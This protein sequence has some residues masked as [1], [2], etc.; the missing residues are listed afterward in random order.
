MLTFSER[1]EPKRV[2]PGAYLEDASS[3]G[4]SSIPSPS[5]QLTLE[6]KLSTSHNRSPTRMPTVKT[7]LLMPP[8]ETRMSSLQHRLAVYKHSVTHWASLNRQALLICV[9]LLIFLTK[10]ISITRPCLPVA[11]REVFE[12]PLFGLASLELAL[13]TKM[14]WR[15]VSMFTAVHVFVLLWVINWGGGLCVRSLRG[16]WEFD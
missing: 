16:E 3:S 12:Y 11:T 1:H 10:M 4:I 13:G 2:R 7:P 9:K 5:A 6:A 14:G 15:Y 8:P